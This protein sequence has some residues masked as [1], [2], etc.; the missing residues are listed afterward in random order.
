[1]VIKSK[2]SQVTIFVI[3]GI[4]IVVS[5]LLFFLLRGEGPL[6]LFKPSI[7]NPQEYI[8]KCTRDAVVEAVNIMLP[9]GGYVSPQNYK[10]YENNKVQYLCYINKYYLPCVNQEPM[11]IQH[12]SQEIQ[13]Y[14]KPKIKDCF[15]SLEQ[16][17]KKKGFSVS[18]QDSED[19]AVDLKP[20]QIDVRIKKKF[21]ISKGEETKSYNSYDIIMQSP[22]YDLAVIAQEIASQEAKF[23]NFEYLG[24]SLLYPKYIIEKDQVGSEETISD[25]YKIKEK[26]SGKELIIAIRSCA[27]P[28]GL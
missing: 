14:I 18:I 21:E 13:D 19:I 26:L 25:I 17:N 16:E 6:S 12:L 8:E 15:Y 22:L 20:R 7:S 2:H 27:M 10:L 5:I 9:Q 23:C 11:Y 28:G 1:M 3:I 4:V 24:F